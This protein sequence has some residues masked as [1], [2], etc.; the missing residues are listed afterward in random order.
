M[1]PFLPKEIPMRTKDVIV[2]PYDE[3]WKDAFEKIVAE[4]REALGDSA[5]AI[6]H[7]GSTSVPGLA[8]KP[9]IDI[10]VVIDRSAFA[11][12]REK[13]EA[14]GYTHEGDL[15]I[16]DREAF[17]YADKPRLMAHHLYVCPQDSEELKRHLAF[18]DY[19]RTHENARHIY[20]RLKERLAARFPHDIESYMEGKSLLIQSILEQCEKDSPQR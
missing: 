8:A 17:K 6:E 19:L 4:L 14:I 7:V 12:V 11:G 15:G 16:P 3:T 9:I 5:L 2:L 20:G 10:D 13:L 1:D 18:R